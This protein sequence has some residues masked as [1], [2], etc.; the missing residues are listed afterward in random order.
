MISC[1]RKT[2]MPSDEASFC[3]SMSSKWCCRSGWCPVCSASSRESGLIT[4]SDKGGLP[5]EFRSVVV[6]LLGHD[7][8]LVEVVLVGRRSRLPFQSGGSP[9]IGSGYLAVP[10]RPHEVNHRQQVSDSQD[11][12]AGAREH[13]QHL[14][15]R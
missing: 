1:A 13:V 12:G 7:R 11:G 10:Q 15:L 14:E 4:V 5:F 6:R 9:W 8:S 2:H 3:C